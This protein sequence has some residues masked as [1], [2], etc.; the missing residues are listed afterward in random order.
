MNKQRKCYNLFNSLVG[1][2]THNN[3][4]F[5]VFAGS[6]ENAVNFFG[7]MPWFK[8][9]EEIYK[10]LEHLK[11]LNHSDKIMCTLLLLTTIN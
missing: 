9:H 2:I 7:K 8:C 4:H 5:A 11:N 1:H 10:E 3:E 6:F